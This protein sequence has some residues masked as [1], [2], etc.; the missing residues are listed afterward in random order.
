MGLKVEDG[1]GIGG[2]A[3]K[4]TFGQRRE[5]EEGG[6]WGIANAQLLDGVAWLADRTAKEVKVATVGA[7]M[8][9]D[10]RPRQSLCGA[11]VLLR[12]K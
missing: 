1:C 6:C 11:C 2:L 4:V 7:R 3:Q 5:R 10:G 8:G 12:L 9:R